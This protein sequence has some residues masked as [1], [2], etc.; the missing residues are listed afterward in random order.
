MKRVEDIIIDNLAKKAGDLNEAGKIN[1]F[2][3]MYEILLDRVCQQAEM[4]SKNANCGGCG[5]SKEE[6]VENHEG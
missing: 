6:T 3:H 4:L 2:I 5:K 1:K